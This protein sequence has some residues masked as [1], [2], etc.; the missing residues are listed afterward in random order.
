MRFLVF[1][2][3]VTAEK[4]GFV[5]RCAAVYETT[6]P[7]LEITKL[8]IGGLQA[9]HARHLAR[10]AIEA[11]KPD[12]LIIEM[13]TSA[14]RTSPRSTWLVE[15]QRHSMEALFEICQSL[16]IGCGLLDLPR[17]G[18]V[19]NTDWTI[20]INTELAR[21]FSIPHR[22][23]PLDTKLLTDEVHP[24]EKGKNVYAA[25]LAGLIEEMRGSQPDFTGLIRTRSFEAYAANELNVMNSRYAQFERAGFKAEVLL[26]DA[27]DTVELMLPITVKVTGILMQMG[28]KSGTFRIR[29]NN[30][31]QDIQCYDQHCYYTRMGGK[32]LAPEITNKIIVTQSTELPDI[33]LLKGEKDTDSR[34]GGIAYVLYEPA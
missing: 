15:D 26:I 2:F 11:C 8:A 20:E 9:N 19:G 10:K 22:I 34:V 1:G 25:S 4:D 12:A 24:T 3:S 32:S 21:K 28:P 6:D 13:A 29:M 5:E 7:D 16:N 17:I 27:G 18:V 31:E 23:V 33:E 14:Y 30:T